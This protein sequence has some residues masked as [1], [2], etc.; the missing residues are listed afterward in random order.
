MIRTIINKTI[1]NKTIAKLTIN[2]K[3]SLNAL[4]TE[5][6]TNIKSEIES[7]NKPENSEIRVVLIEGE[8]GKAFV[9]GA[10]ILEMSSKTVEEIRTFGELGFETMRAIE[11][12]RVPVIAAVNGFALGGG[13]ELALACDLIV[14]SSKS[15][16]AQPEVNLGLITG[17][18]GS[19]RLIHRCGIGISRRLCLLGNMITAE[20]ALKIGLAD[21]VFDDESYEVEV[22]KLAETIAKKPTIAIEATKRVVNQSI[23]EDLLPG[24]RNELDNFVKVFDTDQRKLGIEKFLKKK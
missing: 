22:M 15:K 23:E 13:M 6:L 20:E 17:F 18:G 5:V 2:R 12:C 11:V 1:I 8:G 19:Q 14:A 4:N 10:D 21:F 24:L 9:A 16:F 7:I 3:E